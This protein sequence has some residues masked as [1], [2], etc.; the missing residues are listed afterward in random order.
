[1]TQSIPYRVLGRG[2]QAGETEDEYRRCMLRDM[3]GP[4]TRVLP[5]G[6]TMDEL[7]GLTAE[8]LGGQPWR[9]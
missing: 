2:C 6:K 4:E 9:K 1:M 7:R 5:A 8:A 3:L